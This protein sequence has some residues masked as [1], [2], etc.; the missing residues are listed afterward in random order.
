MTF[1]QYDEVRY[2]ELCKQLSF[3]AANIRLDEDVL[4]TS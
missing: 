1:I 3:N 4:K 2:I